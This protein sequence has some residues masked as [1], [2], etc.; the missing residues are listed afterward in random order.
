MGIRERGFD[1]KLP[2][3]YIFVN[4]SETTNNNEK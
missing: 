1:V 2:H 3:H 4:S